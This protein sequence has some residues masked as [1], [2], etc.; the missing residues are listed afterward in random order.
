MILCK[1]W[2]NQYKIGIQL[3]STRTHEGVQ[4]PLPPLCLERDKKQAL[5][6]PPDLRLLP[7]L[8]LLHKGGSYPTT[9]QFLL[10]CVVPIQLW[11]WYSLY[12]VYIHRHYPYANTYM[13][14]L[15][16][17]FLS[18][19]LSFLLHLVLIYVCIYFKTNHCIDLTNYQGCPNW[20][21]VYI[22]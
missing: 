19:F 14:C 21:W 8:P 13:Y 18:F 10:Y 22:F 12:I 3:P 6:M 1:E 2:S 5:K 16:L 11:L 15:G 4:R 17:L 9:K 7:Q 20:D